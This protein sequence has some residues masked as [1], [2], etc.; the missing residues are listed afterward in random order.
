VANAVNI[1]AVIRAAAEV[2]VVVLLSRQSLVADRGRGLTDMMDMLK[3]LF[4]DTVEEHI[5]SLLIIVTGMCG[6]GDEN[7]DV[8]LL[9]GSMEEGLKEMQWLSDETIR[10]LLSCVSAYDPLD[11]KIKGG[12]NSRLDLL[13]RI[14]SMPCISSP[15]L[16]FK[17]V[18][19]VED[20]HFLEKMTTALKT[21]AEVKL[22]DE[23]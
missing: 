10:R 12:F 18:L 6:A 20:K 23:D 19:T 7:V 3:D 5:A 2:K 21:R 17:T 16:I 14:R 8:E 15:D 4:G 1:R 11:R 22:R 13:E 9:Q